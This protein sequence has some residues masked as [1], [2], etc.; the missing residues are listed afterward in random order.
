MFFKFGG[1]MKLTNATLF[2]TLLLG[3]N[4]FAE[5]LTARFRPCRENPDYVNAGYICADVA[6]GNYTEILATS[7]QDPAVD[8]LLI[9]QA[10]TAGYSQGIWIS[11]DGQ[12]Q[13]INPIMS[14]RPPLIRLVV[15]GL[16]KNS[17]SRPR[18][19]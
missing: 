9:S 19:F 1:I 5:P 10:N 11:I 3:A 14:N 2:F 4:A 6:E 13:R 12:V 18:G 17:G 15:F 16:Q 8:N 7:Q